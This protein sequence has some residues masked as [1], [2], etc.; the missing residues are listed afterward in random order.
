MADACGAFRRLLDVMARLRGPDGCP[1]DLAQDHDSIK[2]HLVEEAY[3]AID[4]LDAADDEHFAEELG[5]LLLQIV[6]HARIAEERGAFD[7]TTVI[8][9][10]LA[11]LKRRHPH[12][13]GEVRLATP[14]E[15]LSS[16]ERIKRAEK[17]G[18]SALDGV[19][20]ALPGLMYAQRI[21]HKAAHVGF[22]W[23][24]SEPVYEKLVEELHELKEA[25]KDPARLGEELGD[26]LFTAVNLGRKL[27]L[28]AETELRAV[29]AKFKRRFVRMEEIAAA[30]GRALSERSLKEQD[31]LWERVKDEEE[32]GPR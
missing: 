31:A 18:K 6:F 10:V 17:A 3:E 14:E 11:K 20:A 9:S 15:V 8:E 1:W 4:A 25:E 19:P 22:D 23:E 21:Q 5:D 24:A 28:E 30:E 13:F 26:L 7:M 27:G 29:A 2:G 12:I 32:E 16:W